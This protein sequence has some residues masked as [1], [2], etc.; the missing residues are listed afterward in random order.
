M[1]AAVNAPRRVVVAGTTDAIIQVEAACAPAGVGV[2]RLSVAHAFHSPLMAPMLPGFAAVLATVRYQP[3]HIKVVSSAHG[4]VLEAD[5]AMD[6]DY[7]RAQVL[8]PVRYAA[9]VEALAQLGCQVLIE[10]GPGGQLSGLGPLT[11]DGPA[12]WVT[13]LRGKGAEWD[14]LLGALGQLYTA[15]VPL[16]WP[17]VDGPTPHRV[18]LPTYPFQRQRYW[19]DPAPRRRPDARRRTAAAG[20]A[21]GHGHGRRRV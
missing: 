7:W 18:S 4:R 6:A 8:A 10:V 19:V 5:E 13:P 17:A 2:R 3:A 21:T 20:P 15:G 9:G 16:D 14:G 1:I 11:L 12:T